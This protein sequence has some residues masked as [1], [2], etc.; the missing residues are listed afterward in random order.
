VS[1]REIRDALRWLNRGVGIV[2]FV[3][4]AT[5]DL[6]DRLYELL[7]EYR[8]AGSLEH[9]YPH[10]MG[11]WACGSTD[12]RGRIAA[13]RNGVSHRPDC[14]ALLA[15]AL[16]RVNDEEDDEQYELDGETPR[17]YWGWILDQARERGV[18]LKAIRHDRDAIERWTRRDPPA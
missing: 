15:A 17:E 1:D 4:G 9:D 6:R 16:A 11:C 2:E 7:L 5:P 10:R 18:N 14:A 12:G 8:L 13:R 3:E